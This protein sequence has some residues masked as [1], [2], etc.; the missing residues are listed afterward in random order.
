[1]RTLELID[2]I[3]DDRVLVFGSLP[4]EGR[5]LDL[6]AHRS[7]H[8][9]IATALRA[10]G[11]LQ[12]RHRLA[13]FRD[14]AVEA[15]ELVDAERWR[16]PD[17]ELKALFDDADPLPGMRR[18]VHPAPHHVLL[19]A[20]RRFVRERTGLDPRRRARIA[21]AVEGVSDVWTVARE[22]APQWGAGLAMDLLESA[23]R[24]GPAPSRSARARAVAEQFT[25]AGSD[26]R[27][28]R[29]R[30]W[31]TA[32]ERPRRGGVISLSGLD[33]AGKSSQAAALC[34]A[35]ERLGF[36][37]ASEW[38]RLAE[39]SVLDVIARPAKRL[40]ALAPAHKLMR[41][42][43]P[44][45]VLH[46]SR[47]TEPTKRL[48]QQSRAMTGAWATIVAGAN[49]WTQR[50]TAVRHIRKG[51]IVVCDRYT[52]DSAVHLRY[53]YGETRRRRFQV[54]LIRL[55][56]PRPQRSY[57]L[58]IAPETAFARKTDHYDLEQLRRQAALY[59]QEYR[60]LG[61][62]R[63]DGERPRQELCSEIASEVWAALEAAKRTRGL[64]P[65]CRRLLTS[66]VQ[67][68]GQKGA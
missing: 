4:P 15:V 29:L 32:L 24:G 40:L 1:M 20:A 41:P 18:L 12:R 31:T 52:L 9:A 8:G 7:Q 46:A 2:G 63:L 33:G 54:W 3:A 55:L 30:A 67:R 39:N 68:T 34:E 62:R 59:R 60:R 38:T 50:S 23:Y 37:A 56:S 49:G 65:V 22:R 35:L 13:R 36:D 17:G 66:L 5:D 26:P 28:A 53:R 57:F 58:D 27:S 21:A 11:F 43:K 64:R 42:R 10:E 6:L 47:L 14:C 19:I 45:D 61:V 48:R 51:T 25:A 16:L 44:D